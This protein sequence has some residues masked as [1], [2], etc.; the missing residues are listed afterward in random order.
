VATTPAAYS[1]SSQKNI[2]LVNISLYIRPCRKWAVAVDVPDR[3]DAF[4]HRSSG[5][6]ESSTC[7][8]RLKK[9]VRVHGGFG[10][11]PDLSFG[12]MTSMVE[13]RSWSQEHGGTASLSNSKFDVD[14]HLDVQML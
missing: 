14:V 1:V 8:E 2:A 3:F 13:R 9:V 6:L 10:S 11:S 5:E 4:G 7:Q 12:E